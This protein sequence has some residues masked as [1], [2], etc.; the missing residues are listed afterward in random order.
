[1]IRMVYSAII[2]RN[3]WKIVYFRLCKTAGLSFFSASLDFLTS[4]SVLKGFDFGKILIY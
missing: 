2:K 3:G 1:M 4:T